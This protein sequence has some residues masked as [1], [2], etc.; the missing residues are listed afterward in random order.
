[1]QDRAL[2]LLATDIQLWGFAEADVQGGVILGGGGSSG[3]SSGVGGGGGS[4]GG[5][6][7]GGGSSSGGG[8]DGGGGGG[9]GGSGAAAVPG[10]SP[11][12]DAK[13]GSFLTV[14]R[15]LRFMGK[16]LDECMDRLLFLAADQTPPE[17]LSQRPL[18]LF[19]AHLPVA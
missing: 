19:G 13:K 1:M 4:G 14:A 2:L 11:A 12:A 16:T 10:G 3:G 8:G 9:G 18:K 15:Y 7:G 5:G 17:A 6:S